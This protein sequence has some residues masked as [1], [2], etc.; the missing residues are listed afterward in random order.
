MKNLNNNLFFSLIKVSIGTTDKLLYTPTQEEWQ[1]LYES[2]MKQTLDGL[3][4]NGVQRIYKNHHE[5]AVNLSTELRMR[6][7]GL[8]VSIQKQ[9]EVMTEH[10]Q[11]TLQFF[12]KNSFPCQVLK[13]H[14]V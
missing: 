10:T 5:Q 1:K 6:W 11:K 13:G 3:C 8:T 14:K 12:R 2:S 7:L 9:N 4:F